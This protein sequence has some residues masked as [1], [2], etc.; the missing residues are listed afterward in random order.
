MKT[1]RELLKM[2][3]AG[4]ATA[5]FALAMPGIVRAA[6]VY[7]SRPIKIIIPFAPGG[8]SDRLS[9]VFMPFLEKELQQPLQV[10][11]MPGG[12][13]VLGNTYLLA[14][15]PD[16]YTISNTAVNY[17]AVTLA[18]G[19]AK[20][21][22][23]DLWMLNL[24][25]RDFTLGAAPAD[26]PLT[27]FN[28]VIDRLKKDPRS[29]SVGMQANSVDYVNMILALRAAG[30][31]TDKM[32]IVTYDGGGVV[33]NAVM[34]GQVDVGFVGAEGYLTLMDKIKPLVGFWDK[35]LLPEFDNTPS[36]GQIGKDMGFDAEF[37]EGSQRGW[38]ISTQLK[39][40]NP[41]VYA[42]LLGAF[43]RATKDPEAIK[44][45]EAQQLPLHWYGPEESNAAYLSTVNTLM[46]YSDL[47]KGS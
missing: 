13:T 1:R 17:T 12:G 30:I 2:T 6:D 44:A 36:I 29:V 8:M 22:G 45:S 35:A 42:T 15:K 41:D 9:R 43:E 37:I 5:G 14:Q 23:E 16:G 3:A 28:E 18:Q 31:E 21:K 46:K 10:E 25:S 20:F 40:E 39:N 47:L 27:S 34:G 7:P 38:Q 11:Y 4:A 32:R 26:S 33:R 24:P 19:L